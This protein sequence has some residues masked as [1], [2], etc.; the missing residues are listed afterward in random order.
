VTTIL[1]Q[2]VL[3]GVLLVF[4]GLFSG[5][6]TALFSLK[7]FQIRKLER[8]PSR[9]SISVHSLLSDPVRLLVT[10]LVGNTLVNVAAS[11]VGTNIV[12]HVMHR[13]VVGISV[14]VMSSLI[15][16]FGEIVPK[17]YA[18]NRP[19][20]TAL[21]TSRL[22]SAAVR[23]MMP[24]RAFFTALSG[25]AA[26]IRLPGAAMPDHELAHVAEAVAAG[27]SQGVLDSLERRMLAGFLK[28][29]H[30][31]VQNIM[32]PRTEVFMLYAGTR[33]GDAVG[34]VKS[35]GYSRVPIFDRDRRDAIKGVVYVK[36]L[37]Q[38]QYSM[39]L[40]LSAIARQPVYVPES[41]ALVDLLGEFVKGAAHFAVVVDEYGTFSGIVTLDDIIEEIVGEELNVR[42]KNTYRKRTRSTYEVSAR[43]ELEYFNAL[44]GTSLSD[45]SAE[46]IGGYILNRTERIPEQGEVL[47]LDGIRFKI[48]EADARQIKTLQIGKK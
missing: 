11:S 17:T 16:V 4:S 24:L 19:V 2:I 9:R 48:L 43:M 38:K 5:S 41:K 42:S 20:K 29:E 13:G 6:E 32:T 22:I 45:K 8:Q 10:I 34:L 30:E 1:L 44:L 33:L 35:A 31:S 3:L 18:V 28:L 36:D 25:L 26:R 23:L 40:E 27:H 14:A 39:D 7:P 46:T 15:L 21:G 37:L 47:V 12:G